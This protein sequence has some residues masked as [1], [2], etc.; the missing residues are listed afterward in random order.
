MSLGC[1]RDN[2]SDSPSNSK[3][4]NRLIWRPYNSHVG[5]DKP[6]FFMRH[7]IRDQFRW[8]RPNAP[9]NLTENLPTL[10]LPRLARVYPDTAACYPEAMAPFFAN[11]PAFY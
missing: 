3:L 5:P 9:E 4:P 2:S 1:S 10:P 6:M 11:A 7:V 8:F